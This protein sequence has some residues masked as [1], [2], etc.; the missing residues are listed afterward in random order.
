MGRFKMNRLL[1]FNIYA[2]RALTDNV[3][4]IFKVYGVLVFDR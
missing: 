4:I 1:D 2:D 3:E